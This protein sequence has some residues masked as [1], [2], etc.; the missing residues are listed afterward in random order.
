MYL[1]VLVIGTILLLAAIIKFK[2]SMADLRDGVRVEAV[3]VDQDAEVDREDGKTRVMY[4]PVF[5]FTTLGGEE[6]DWSP[7]ISSSSPSHKIGDRETLLYNPAD[8]THV[9]TLGYWGVFRWPVIILLLAMPFLIIGG[10]YFV[11]MMLFSAVG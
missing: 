6:V 3:V 2:E 8:T 7:D 4:R 9:T 11:A 1:L 10:G 5:R